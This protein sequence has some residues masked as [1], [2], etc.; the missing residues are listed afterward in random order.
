MTESRKLVS[1]VTGSVLSA[2]L[3]F[4]GCAP[5]TPQEIAEESAERTTDSASE[6][7]QVQQNPVRVVGGTPVGGPSQD[8]ATEEEPVD[9]MLPPD[10]N[11]MADGEMIPEEPLEEPVVEEEPVDEIA[12]EDDPLFDDIPTFTDLGL[13]DRWGFP[14][15]DQTGIFRLLDL[16]V[17][18][19][20][21]GMLPPPNDNQNV[22][23]ETRLEAQCI[24]QG[25]PE[26]ICRQR[27]GN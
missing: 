12:P 17:D 27:Y 23:N 19:L 9:Q 26:F 6:E 2:F 25:E 3:L 22:L 24:A 18:G 11:A 21:F 4:V 5:M 8:D 7:D 15:Y 20:S 14:V 1:W 13:V 16:A 10:E